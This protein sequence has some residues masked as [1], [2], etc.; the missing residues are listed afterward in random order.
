MPPETIPVY[1]K[2]NLSISRQRARFALVNIVR[3]DR[4]CA[5]HDDYDD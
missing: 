2:D 4:N 3:G 5:D 1:D